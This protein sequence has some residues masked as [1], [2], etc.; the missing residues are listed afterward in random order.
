MAA[1]KSTATTAAASP[2]DIVI[3]GDSVA[4]TLAGGTVRSFPEFDPWRPEQSPFDPDVVVLRSAAKPGC[5]F[6]PGVLVVPGSAP[7]NLSP[8]CRG[9]REDLGAALGDAE[10]PVVLIALSNDAGDRLVDGQRVDLGTAAHLALLGAWLDDVRQSARAKGGDVGLIALPPRTGVSARDADVGG[11]RE[12]A[13]RDELE[14]YAATRP[15][16]RVLDLFEQVCPDGDCEH[17]VDGFDPAWR[18]D[19]M[20]YSPEGARWVAA[21]LTRSLLG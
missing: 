1:A 6:L 2:I 15:G 9:W 12:D 16:V 13:M 3:E 7:A 21:W 14:A 20:H 5:S 17:P 4:H 18:W 10:Q 19:G 11:A 8:L